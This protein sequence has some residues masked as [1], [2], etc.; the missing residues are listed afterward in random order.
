MIK[1]TYISGEYEILLTAG[2]GS[3][4]SSD[5]FLRNIPERMGK[6]IAEALNRAYELGVEDGDGASWNNYN[7]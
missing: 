6:R 7:G 4:T 1:F 3:D 5:V 2:V